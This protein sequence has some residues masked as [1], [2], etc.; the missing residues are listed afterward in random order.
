MNCLENRSN[1]NN[2]NNTNYLAD[3][4][5]E[6]YNYIFEVYVDNLKLNKQNAT[7]SVIFFYLTVIKTSPN[8][9]Q[10]TRFFF[11]LLLKQK[12]NLLPMM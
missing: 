12:I 10:S 1:K 6:N 3:C 7:K 8:T 2:Q 9:Y 5:H 4:V 11:Q